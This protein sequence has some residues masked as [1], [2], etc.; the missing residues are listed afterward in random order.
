MAER[1]ARGGT[2]NALGQESRPQRSSDRILSAAAEIAKERGIH[3]ATIAAVSQRSGLPASSIYW[4]FA[5]KD[6]L[7]A[8]VIRADLARWLTTVPQWSTTEGQPLREGLAAILL[9]A[10]PALRDVPD[11]LR[12][13]MQVIL[14]QRQEYA[15]AREAFLAVRAQVSAMITA[16]LDRALGAEV[17]PSD[18]EAL[19]RLILNFTDG[20]VVGS[21][22]FEELDIP[23]YS[24]LFLDVFMEVAASA[25]GTTVSSTLGG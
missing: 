6:A 16:W 8:A 3:G 13:G 23:E 5:D 18:V 9:P 17:A 22:I 4:H 10:V 19:T 14:D 1:A 2:A 7:F 15:A 20:I 24:E 21:Q 11:F 12:I 25:A